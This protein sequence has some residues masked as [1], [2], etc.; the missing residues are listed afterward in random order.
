MADGIA[1]IESEQPN[2]VLIDDQ[3][4]DGNSIEAV[5]RILKKPSNTQFVLLSSKEDRA[6]FKEALAAGC[7]SV[8]AKDLSMDD[9]L[10]T[11]RNV[12]RF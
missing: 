11:I 5:R 2:V 8:I 9:L 10:G 6:F 4:P 7:V 3:L 1:L 12:A